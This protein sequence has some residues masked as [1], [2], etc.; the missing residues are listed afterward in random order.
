M[1]HVKVV[2]D[3]QWTAHESD[4]LNRIAVQF[5]K[6]FS[7]DAGVKNAQFLEFFVI[8]EQ[9][10]KFAIRAV[11]HGKRNE[12]IAVLGQGYP[13]PVRYFETPDV[14]VLDVRAESRHAL[15]NVRT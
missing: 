12:L 10:R 11:T 4:E 7:G 8:L 2:R 14:E 6:T 9:Q 1:P 3:H 15:Q 5:L 13:A